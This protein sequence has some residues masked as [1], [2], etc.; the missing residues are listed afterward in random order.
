MKKWKIILIFSIFIL[1]IL[2]LLFTI[3]TKYLIKEVTFEEFSRLVSECKFEKIAIDT[4]KTYY[5][6]YGNKKD[7]IIQI[8]SEIPMFPEPKAAEIEIKANN[9]RIPIIK[10]SSL[11]LF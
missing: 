3:Y 2:F 6:A 1:F 10:E 9:C 11:F 7:S 4:K 5:Q 8:R